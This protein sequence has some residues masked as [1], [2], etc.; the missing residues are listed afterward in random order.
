MMVVFWH[1]G[2]LRELQVTGGRLR[3]NHGIELEKFGTIHD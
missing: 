3:W 2:V 1:G